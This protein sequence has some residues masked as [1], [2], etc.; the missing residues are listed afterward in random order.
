MKRFY[1]IHC[2]SKFNPSFLGTMVRVPREEQMLIEAFG[3]EYRAYIQR[4]G[5]YFPKF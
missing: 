3:D 1:E 2:F 5:R 4:T